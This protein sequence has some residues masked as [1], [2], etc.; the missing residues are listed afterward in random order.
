M[1]NDNID[2]AKKVGNWLSAI[3]LGNTRELI[4]RIDERTEHMAKDLDDIRPRVWDMSPKVDTLWK[5]RT[6]PANSPRQLNDRGI[7]ILE[8]SGIKQI[9]DQKKEQL[10]T[11]VRATDPTNAYDAEQA[12]ITVMNDLQMHC[13]DVTETLKTGAF[14]VGA[15]IPTLLYV[16]SV[17][18]R[19]QIFKDLG[20]SLG[21][22]DQTINE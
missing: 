8:Q 5:D 14:N 7:L 10:L 4:A 12:I 1:G 20:F 21:D 2:K 22:I 11:L 9:V 13:P 6:A 3:L 16:G 17:Y 18:L 15:D 19:N